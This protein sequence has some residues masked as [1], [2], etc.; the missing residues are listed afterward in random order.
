MASYSDYDELYYGLDSQ[1]DNP[2]QL[3]QV[4]PG[5]AHQHMLEDGQRKKRKRRMLNATQQSILEDVFLHVQN[6]SSIL[7][8]NLAAQL[9]LPH[10]NIQIWFQNRR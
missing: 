9:D 4:D 10:R 1:S 8:A 7:R 2:D 3:S 5:Y 6:P